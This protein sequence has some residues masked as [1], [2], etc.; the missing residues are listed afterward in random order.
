MAES[1]LGQESLNWIRR[2]LDSAEKAAFTLPADSST[3]WV[4]PSDERLQRLDFLSR[5]YCQLRQVVE[6]E[7]K[8]TVRVIPG[9]AEPRP[10]VAGAE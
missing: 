9:L 4:P 1:V 8:P 3:V 10:S 2:L 7:T 5:L 6:A